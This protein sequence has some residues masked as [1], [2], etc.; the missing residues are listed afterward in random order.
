MSVRTTGGADHHPE[1]GQPHEMVKNG[2]TLYWC[3]RCRQWNP[4]HAT[5]THV[6]CS[7]LIERKAQELLQQQGVTI[8]PSANAS[9]CTPPSLASTASSLTT[10][11]STP[12]ISA[13]TVQL[14]SALCRQVFQSHFKKTE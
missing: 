10:N 12:S 13:Y 8:P 11:E 6:S 14:L 9:I 1:D 7:E 2:K 4:N 3:A 5:N